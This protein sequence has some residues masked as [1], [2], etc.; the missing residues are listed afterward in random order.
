[1][2]NMMRSISSRQNAI[3]GTFRDLAAD[4]PLDG[5][6]LLLD[7]E[8][9]VTDARAAGVRIEQVAVT[10]DARQRVPELVESVERSGADVVVVTTAVM[11]AL[12]PVRTPSGIIAIASRNP[13]DPARVFT[14]HGARVIALVDVQDPG[15]V[16]AIVRAA[17]ALG[18]TAAVVSGASANPFSW[19]ALRG[20]MGSTLR[21]PVLAGLSPE[22]V[23]QCAKKNGL[24]TIASTAR[25]G[26]APSE[27]DWSGRLVVFV[28]GEG[29]GLSE[30]FVS[31]CDARV[32]IPMRPP[33]ESLN[34]AVSAALLLYEAQRLH[35]S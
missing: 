10:E 33:V 21:L 32:T 26:A 19:K 5:S 28:G 24:R 20:S 29:P 35:Q 17:E 6:R 23:V 1:M 8:H 22:S 9:L 34:V 15:N 4:A 27:A 18:A 13:L 31:S 16:G 3:V 12:S 2:L 25:E 7:G 30:Q 11:A 14:D